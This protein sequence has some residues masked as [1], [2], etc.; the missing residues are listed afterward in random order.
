MSINAGNI[1]H[2]AGNNVIDRIQSA[3]LTNPNQGTQTIREVGQMQVVD[4]IPGEPEFTFSMETLDVST[5]LMAFLTG[6]FGAQAEPAG[7]PGAADAAGTEYKWDNVRP[8]NIISPWK[9]PN[10]DLAG[11][12]LSGHIIPA[13]WPTSM[14]LRMGAQEN[15]SQ[16]VELAGGQY[17]Y[18]PGAPVEEVAVGDGVIAAFT[19]SEGT[20]QHRIGGGGGTTFR[21]VFGVFVNAVPQVEGIDYAVTGGNGAPATITFN[22]APAN[23]AQ[24]RFTYFTI[25]A[26]TFA[27]AVHASALV[28]P[29]AVR[30]R[31]IPVF[32]GTGGA[33][34]R[35]GLVQTA[36]INATIQGA[37]EYE[38]G[39]EGS[40]SRTETGTDCTGT[41]TVRAR[42]GLGFLALLQ[43]V[44]G[45]PAGEVIGY[46]NQ[47]PIP[48]ELPIENP[49]N[50]GTILKT[51]YVPDAIFDIPATPARVNTPVDFAL[52]FNSQT[53]T[54][55]EFKGAKP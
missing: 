7:A 1:L 48:L 45:V 8:V 21:Q 15:Y 20:T 2:V 44:T 37:A 35:I 50:P 14:R 16:T 4:K 51:V 30:G 55:S 24:V 6:K 36:E 26:K 31:N 11:N 27:P 28:K 17:Y 5:D 33:R 18:G 9:D 32:L 29:G 52:T 41:L 39:T 38:M 53:G 13:Y 47:N 42:D 12:I 49:K 22:V 10:A 19:T 46:L 34:Q 54:Y 23:G 43:K 25:V 40:V 3:G